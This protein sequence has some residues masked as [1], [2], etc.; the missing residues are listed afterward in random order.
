MPRDGVA[1]FVSE[2]TPQLRVSVRAFADPIQKTGL[3]ED[4]ST[5]QRKCIGRFVVEDGDRG[6]AE[7]RQFCRREQVNELVEDAFD[8]SPGL[9]SWRG[10]G[11][12]LADGRSGN[13]ADA[14]VDRLGQGERCPLRNASDHRAAHEK[15]AYECAE[16]QRELEEGAPRALAR[17]KAVRFRCL[18]HP[19]LLPFR[20]TSALTPCSSEF[21]LPHHIIK[22]QPVF[23]LLEV[24]LAPNEVVVAEAGAMVARASHV[25]M[26]VKLNAPAHAGFF[27]KLRAFVIALVRKLFAGETFFVNHFSS[28]QGGW[29]WLAPALS[30]AVKHIVLQGNTM[31]FSAGAFLA[32]SGDITM[33]PRF[34]GCRSLLAKEGAFFLETSGTGELWITSYGAIEELQCN[35]SYVVDNGHLVGFDAS[36]NFTIKA[37]GGGLVGLL[38]SGEGL[39]CEFQ[40]QGRIFIQ[41]RNVSALVEWLTPLLPS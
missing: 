5:W 38:G 28:P 22:H 10:P 13:L 39:V 19:A 23:A 1:E 33:R 2:C 12:P 37:P 34:G 40:G 11:V 9:G 25:A 24:Q 7:P 4:L 14:H 29:V 36:L 6:R 15:K 41:T 35:G 18:R 32:F 8:A 16:E 26:A 3:H 17:R 21:I 31:L 27:G 30:G 20:N